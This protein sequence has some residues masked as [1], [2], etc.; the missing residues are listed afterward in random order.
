MK[1]TSLAADLA[2]LDTESS[3]RQ[4][5][6]EMPPDEPGRGVGKSGKV[7]QDD[8]EAGELCY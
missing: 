5:F 7:I 6:P 4:R 1:P 8:H 2:A 3:S